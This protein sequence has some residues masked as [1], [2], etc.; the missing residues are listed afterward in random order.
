MARLEHSLRLRSQSDWGESSGDCNRAWRPDIPGCRWASSA[1]VPHDS[2]LSG[3]RSGLRPDASARACRREC[4]PVR[5]D[6]PVFRRTG[7]VS[8]AETAERPLG[9]VG[10]RGHQ[11]C[12]RTFENR[13]LPPR[14]RAAT[15]CEDDRFSPHVTLGRFK[16]G[17][18]GTVDLTAIVERYRSWSCGEFT[19]SEV[20]G[21]ASRLGPSRTDL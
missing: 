18:R 11:S 4:Q 13:S 16:P 6:R 19:A 17:R 20:V 8:L 14:H 12:S 7:R 3:G 9:R 15:A 2:R 10:R 21:F 1:I 5:A